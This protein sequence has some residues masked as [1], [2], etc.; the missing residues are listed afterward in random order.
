METL[1]G[2]LELLPDKTEIPQLREAIRLNSAPSDEHW[3]LYSPEVTK[4]VQK[5]LVVPSITPIEKTGV[6]NWLSKL[7][8][9]S[10]TS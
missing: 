3:T 2:L 7:R 10:S 4:A 6:P 1:R 5:R 9:G 8:T